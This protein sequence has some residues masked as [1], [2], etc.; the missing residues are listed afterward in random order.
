M[1]KFILFILLLSGIFYSKADNYPTGA[2]SLGMANASVAVPSIWSVYYNQAALAYLKGIQSAIYY[3]NRFN[4]PEFSV[5]SLA[6]AMNTKP[7]TFGLSYT[8]FG[9]SKYSDNK[10]GLAYSMKIGKKLA[11]GIQLDYFLIK[12][13]AYYGN[14][15]AFSG[16]IGIYAE[17]IDNLH[18]AAHLFNPW[19]TK[20]APY[21]DERLSTILSIGAA[22]DFSDQ[23]KISFE[24]DK[25]F[26][27]PALIKTGIQ[28][29]PVENIILR[30]GISFSGNNVFPAFGMGYNF[31]K[32]SFSI[33][34][35]SHPILGFKSGVSLIYRF[36]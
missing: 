35:E 24:T 7:G 30:T 18:I 36:K 6:F 16:E 4:F 13:Q 2:S 19:R 8:S 23:L 5:K 20:I 31:N 12:Q 1:K 10:I 28:F 26:D 32:F 27:Q 34:F 3:E 17:P 25:N 33:A 21:Q 14:I 29:E 22:Y 15:K 11:L 9:F